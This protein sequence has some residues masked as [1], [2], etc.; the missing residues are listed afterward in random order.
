[1]EIDAKTTKDIESIVAQYGDSEEHGKSHIRRVLSYCQ[2]IAT[3]MITLV[4]TRV[5]LLAVLVT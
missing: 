3:G 5:C 1:M 2:L 4:N